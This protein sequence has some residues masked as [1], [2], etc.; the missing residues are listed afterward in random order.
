MVNNS[1]YNK[2]L[3]CS[4]YYPKV[5]AY[6]FKE[7]NDF[8]MSAHIHDRVEIMYVISGTCTVGVNNVTFGM[9][10][11]EF[12]LIDANVSHNLVVEKNCPCRMLNI[13]FI[14]GEKPFITPS[15]GEISASSISFRK[16]LI[17]KEPFVI[18]R[19]PEEVYP[20]LKSLIAELDGSGVDRELIIQLLMMQLLVKISRL[21]EERNIAPNAGAAYVRKAMTYMQQHYDRDIKVEDIAAAVNLHPSYLHRVFKA[22][23]GITLLEYLTNLR[24]EKS[25]MLLANT[26]IPII[27]VSEYVGINSRQYFTY[28]FKRNTGITPQAFRKAVNKMV[29]SKE[30]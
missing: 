14:F 16:F 6:Y 13:E 9:K 12:I 18:L 29:L 2:K 1:L 17:E 15:Y 3:L 22:N 11:G 28:V 27:D 8:H 24:V 26:D 20:A 30:G 23:Q 10:K 4:R 21:S 19:D 7:W 25:K 5:L